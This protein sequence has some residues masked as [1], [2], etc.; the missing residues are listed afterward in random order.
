MQVKQTSS[1]QEMLSWLQERKPI[2]FVKKCRGMTILIGS[3]AAA[4]ADSLYP[5]SAPNLQKFRPLSKETDIDLICAPDVDTLNSL[6]GFVTFQYAR[7][8]MYGEKRMIRIMSL[9]NLTRVEI[10]VPLHHDLSSF[11]FFT[12]W[13]VTLT[14][15]SRSFMGLPPLLKCYIATPEVLVAFKKSHIY[16]TEPKT[17]TL[18]LPVEAIFIAQSQV[19]D[20]NI[21]DLHFL[22]KR[23]KNRTSD[24]LTNR[25]LK[26]RRE[27]TLMLKAG[28]PAIHVNL[29]QSNEAF[30]DPNN[31]HIPTVWDHD[32]VHKIV[33]F[34]QVPMYQRIKRDQSKA[35]CDIKLFEALTHTERI[36]DVQEEAMVLALE[37]YLL[38]KRDEIPYLHDSAFEAYKKSLER[39]CTSITKGWFR[40]FAL[41]NYFEILDLPKNRDLI[42]FRDYIRT[43]VQKQ[44]QK[45]EVQSLL[46]PEIATQTHNYVMKMGEN[47]EIQGLSAQ[48]LVWPSAPHILKDIPD[49]QQEAKIWTV[50][51]YFGYIT[52]LDFLPLP[53]EI[54]GL[55]VGYWN[56]HQHDSE[57]EK[58]LARVSVFV[59]RN[60]YTSGDCFNDVSHL[61]E[62]KIEVNN[63]IQWRWKFCKVVRKGVYESVRGVNENYVE[64]NR[65]RGQLPTQFFG[66]R[67][68]KTLDDDKKEVPLEEKQMCSE[69]FLLNEIVTMFG[70]VIRKEDYVYSF[71]RDIMNH[72]QT[73]DIATIAKI[74]AK[75]QKAPVAHYFDF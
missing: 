7:L 18:G 39:I 21:Y 29:N 27:E 47:Y 41:L 60:A 3:R 26:L 63:E 49:N 62:L 53:A 25:L 12:C 61:F 75:F 42:M 57:L 48:R 15:A 4:C 20:Q 37:R 9:W 46:I 64:E 38:P 30:L 66:S 32:E 36:Q 11:L 14:M 2:I 71:I 8:F 72:G 28:D 74:F 35:A 17:K 52:Q 45:A 55:C 31:L 23:C 50:L 6:L 73:C 33:M 22:L 58:G 34:G 5:T 19:F 43:L 24:L 59:K 51:G 16:W 40:E 10:E 1:C 56:Y 13:R 68:V 70:E 67:L 44:E 69:D 65:M 54:I